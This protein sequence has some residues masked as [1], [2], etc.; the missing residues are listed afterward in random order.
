MLWHN[1][2]RVW[3]Q[4]TGCQQASDRSAAS[5]HALLTSIVSADCFII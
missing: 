2:I 1:H 5:A 3:L 4:R